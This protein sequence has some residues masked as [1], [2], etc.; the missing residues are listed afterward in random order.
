MII[1]FLFEYHPLDN[2]VIF[3]PSSSLKGDRDLSKSKFESNAGHMLD[4][5]RNVEPS[6]K[7]LSHLHIIT[8]KLDSQDV[9]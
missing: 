5:P 8:E 7:V 9:P 6:V 3:N 1:L 2:R 4:H